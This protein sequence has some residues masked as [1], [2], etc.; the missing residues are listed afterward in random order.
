LKYSDSPV[1]AK[2]RA[3]NPTD[4]VTCSIVR[5]ELLHGAEKCGNRDR[6]VA[7]VNRALAPFTSLP[8]ADADAV[9]YAR[10]R[11]ELET[12]GQTIGPHDLQIAAIAVRHGV[13]LV[14]SNLREFSRVHGLSLEDWIGSTAQR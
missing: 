1:H 11:H 2:L 8:F 3:L 4:V 9:E 7:I 10:I 14:T 6:R 13:I 5:S 12:E